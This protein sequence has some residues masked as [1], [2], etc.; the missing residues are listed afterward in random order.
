MFK[1]VP[2]CGAVIA[3]FVSASADQAFD[4]G[5][6]DQLKN[7]LGDATKKI[8]AILLCEE[9]GNV[10]VGFGHRGLRVVRG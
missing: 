5:L 1:P 8:A 10:H 2:P 6:H 3:A 4:V 9:L 7:G